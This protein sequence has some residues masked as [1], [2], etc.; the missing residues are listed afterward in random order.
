M[1]LLLSTIGL[2]KFDVQFQ[3]VHIRVIAAICC[4]E[5][6][7]PVC[8]KCNMGPCLRWRIS[9]EI[10]VGPSRGYVV[11]EVNTFIYFT[12]VEDRLGGTESGGR[13]V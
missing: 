9:L 4:I 12:I 3:N 5:L 7:T 8:F 1:L 13:G 6:G 11:D 2:V 10:Y